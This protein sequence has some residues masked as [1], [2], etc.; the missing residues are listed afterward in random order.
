M[1]SSYFNSLRFKALSVYIVLVTINLAASAWTIYN[2]G[3]L[4]MS[5][6]S[7]LHNNVPDIMAAE[8]MAGTI[9]RHESALW[10][11]MNRDINNGKI[12]LTEAKDDFFQSYHIA[13]ENRTPGDV[14]NVLDDI[15]STYQGYLINADSLIALVEQGKYE[16]AKAYYANDVRMFSQ[17]LLDNCFWLIEIQQK[18]LQKVSQQTRSA[19]DEAIVAAL[20]AS[21][22]AAGLSIVTMVQFTRR[23]IQP[24]ERLTSTVNRIGRGNLDI[25]IDI[26]T[27]DEIG[28]LSREFNKMTERLRKYEEMNVD[29]ILAEKQKSETIVENL[30]DAILV[31]DAEGRI[32]LLNRSAEE[33]LSIKE[34]NVLDKPIDTIIREPRIIALFHPGGQGDTAVPYIQFSHKGRPVYLRPRISVIR[35]SAG[36]VRGTVVILQDVTQFKELDRM[37]SDFMAAVSHEFR[38]PLTSINMSVDILR[39]K[40]LGPL[41]DK[42]EEMLTASKQDCE[43]LTKLVRDLL[44]LSKLESGS[45]ELREDLLDIRAVV[46]SAIHSYTLPFR[47]KGVALAVTAPERLPRFIGDEQQFSWVISNLVGNAL[48]YTDAGGRVDIILRGDTENFLTVHVRDTGRGIAPEYLGKIFDKFVQVK[49]TFDSTPGSVGLGLSIAKEI[50][51]MYGGKIWVESTPGKGSVFSFQLPAVQDQPA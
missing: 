34:T 51:E 16:H 39:Q 28:Q 5:M 13:N 4:T 21:L 25:K 14:A 49:E 38:T 31:C 26:D 8:T 45:M 1:R 48:R 40:I 32:Q 20:I 47:E 3:R 41:T 35:S 15:Q 22:I 50:I 23:V 46:E 43:R 9:E 7:L 29:R 44:Q 11:F 27:D 17:R 10:L 19:S 18:E 6:N 36:A 33:L 12:K 30:S 2:F 37:K 24:A 42:Q